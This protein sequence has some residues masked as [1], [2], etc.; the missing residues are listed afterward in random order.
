MKESVYT[1]F[2][3]MNSFVKLIKNN[4]NKTNKNNKSGVLVIKFIL[5]KLV[6]ILRNVSQH[7]KCSTS[8]TTDSNHLNLELHNFNEKLVVSHS[9][10]T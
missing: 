10:N 5:V 2:T 8:G 9:E 6:D 4:K 3:T 7:K 1:T